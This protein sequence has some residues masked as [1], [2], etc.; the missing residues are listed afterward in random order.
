MP[1]RGDDRRRLQKLGRVAHARGVPLF[2]T[3]DVLY[4]S[5]ERR[6]LQDVVTCIREACHAGRGRTSSR[7]QCRTSS[8][9]TAGDG[10]VCFRDVPEAIAETVRF[11]ERITFS[12]AQLKYNYPDEPVP[13]G[14]TRAATSGRPHL[15]RRGWRYPEGFPDKVR[16]TLEKELR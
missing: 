3:N 15:G 10:G 8:E 11:A 1:Y 6:E 16:E 12:L 14:K 4:H 2:A 9:I 5:P 7:S 13:K